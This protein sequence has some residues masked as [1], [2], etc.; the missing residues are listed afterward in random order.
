M[1]LYDVYVFSLQLNVLPSRLTGA[2]VSLPLCGSGAVLLLQLS[3]VT[4]TLQL[5]EGVWFSS[6]GSLWGPLPCGSPQE[7]Y[8]VKQ[9]EKQPYPLGLWWE[10]PAYDLWTTFRV[11]LPFTRRTVHICSQIALWS[12]PVESK[13]SDSLLSFRPTFS[14]PFNSNRQH[15]CWYNS[16]SIPGFCSDV[17]LSLQV[18]L[19]FSLSSG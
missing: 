11:I 5:G 2:A 7:P 3:R 16:I 19:T 9:K 6:F 15:L 14:A 13:K 8:P 17:W 10:W 18:A 4:R 1:Y 12:G